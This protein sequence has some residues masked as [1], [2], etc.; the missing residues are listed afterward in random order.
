MLVSDQAR[1]HP[2]VQAARV[3]RAIRISAHWSGAPGVCDDPG[4]SPAPAADVEL[5]GAQLAAEAALGLLES[6]VLHWLD[7]PELAAEQASA[8][9]TGL[10]WSGLTG[11]PATA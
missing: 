9:L 7:H 3:E 2:I 4:P 5:A 8:L 11:P 10:L 1:Q 6:G